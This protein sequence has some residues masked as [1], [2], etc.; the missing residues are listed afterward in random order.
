MI[1]LFRC[2]ICGDPYVGDEPPAN[3]PFCGAHKNFIK[4]A[5][6]AKVDFDVKLNDC[7]EFEVPIGITNGKAFL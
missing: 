3:C 4:E 6:D 1:K 2:E 5:K 7:G